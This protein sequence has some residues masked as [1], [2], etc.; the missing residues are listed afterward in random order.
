MRRELNV[1]PLKGKMSK[2]DLDREFTSDVNPFRVYI[3]VLVNMD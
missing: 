3:D 1:K 2:P